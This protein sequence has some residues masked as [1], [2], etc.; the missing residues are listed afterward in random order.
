MNNKANVKEEKQVEVSRNDERLSKRICVICDKNVG[1]T[2]YRD[3][4]VCEECLS[5]IKQM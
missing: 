4:M 2:V 1:D 3:K 5:F